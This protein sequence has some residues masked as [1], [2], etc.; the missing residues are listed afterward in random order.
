MTEQTVD[1]GIFKAYDV[2]GTYPDQMDGDVAYRIGRAFARVLSDRATFA[3]LM[4]VYVLEAYRGRGL[5]VRLITAVMEHPDLQGLRRFM[6]ATRD[7]HS[8]YAR[9]GFVPAVPER[10]MEIVRTELYLEKPA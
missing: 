4:D 10:L 9:F 7:A 1:R 3:Y 6:L 2:R 5:C 8:L